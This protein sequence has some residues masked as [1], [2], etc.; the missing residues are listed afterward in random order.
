MPTK[1]KWIPEPDSEFEYDS[2]DFADGNDDKED[3]VK[4]VESPKK[5]VKEEP[6]TSPPKTKKIKKSKKPVTI[7]SSEEEETITLESGETIG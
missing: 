3:T 5:I 1:Q 6:E 4:M 7:E 2:D